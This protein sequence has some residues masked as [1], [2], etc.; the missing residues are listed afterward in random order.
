MFIV[1][2]KG[3]IIIKLIERSKMKVMKVEIN[4]DGNKEYKSGNEIYE[5]KAEG[6]FDGDN[7]Y[8]GEIN[9]LEFIDKIV[10]VNLGGL[11]KIKDKESDREVERA[12]KCSKVGEKMVL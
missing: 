4:R 2:V 9:R 3:K 12:R 10:K 7:K 5:S 8:K 6:E 1:K 11:A